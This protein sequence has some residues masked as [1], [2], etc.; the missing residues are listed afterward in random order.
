MNWATMS[1]IALW[2]TE[3][4][5][6]STVA[7]SHDGRLAATGNGDGVIKVWD[8]QHGVCI[9]Q[10]VRQ[11]EQLPSPYHG[12]GIK[13][14]TFSPDNQYL[15]ATGI[16][17]D[18]VY[19]WYPGTGTPLANFYDTQ[20][21][22]RI[23][24]LARPVAFSPNNR[25]LACTGPADTPDADFIL[26]W[27]VVTGERIACL[28]EQCGFVN[29]LCFS[30]CGQSLAVGEYKGIVQVW[31]VNTWKNHGTFQGYDGVSRMSVC[32]SQEGILHAMEVSRNTAVVWGV[33]RHEK[34]YKYVEKEGHLQNALFSNSSHFIVA[35]GKRVG[36]VVTRRHRTTRVSSFTYKHLSRFRH[37][38]AR[39]KKVGGW[40]SR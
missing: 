31:D 14:L 8:I 12:T 22:S 20:G 30:P 25:L 28:T 34:R 11:S 4:G 2:E 38:L 18:I 3:R 6:V 21:A 7:I 29:S 1:P 15:A 10:M 16:R 37:V 33:E 9:S 19:T 40:V 26:V 36:R 13:H 24:V 39:W 27:D 23:R 5:V 32:Y 17:D 35:G